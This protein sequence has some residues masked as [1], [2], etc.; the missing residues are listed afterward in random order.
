ML[1]FSEKVMGSSVKIVGKLLV[2]VLVS[3]ISVSGISQQPKEETRNIFFGGG[4][5]YIDNEQVTELGDF[6]KTLKNI[7]Y[8]DVTIISHT[9]NIGG[10]E[11]NQWLSDMRSRSVIQ[12]LRRMGV[13]PESIKF[14]S[15]GL[16]NPTFNNNSNIGRM[17]NRRVDITFTP[18]VF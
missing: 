6:V 4:S 14:R 12:Q 15:D 1:N 18:I 16:E 7:D 13:S 17:R 3:G 5:Y 8:Y 10:K 9:D 11:Y 2:M